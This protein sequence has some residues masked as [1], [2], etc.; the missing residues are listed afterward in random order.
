MTDQNPAPI[1]D[2]EDFPPIKIHLR[3][4]KGEDNEI[5][6]DTKVLGLEPYVLITVGEEG[7]VVEGSHLGMDEV[8]GILGVLA[9]AAA[10]SPEATP[11]TLDEILEFMQDAQVSAR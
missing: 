10:G 3:N 9:A 4:L 6:L 8:A 2:D 1:E 5:R 11:G 7:P